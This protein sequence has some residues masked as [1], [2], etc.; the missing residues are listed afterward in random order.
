MKGSKKRSIYFDDCFA[1]STKFLR[2]QD[3]FKDGTL[4]YTDLVFQSADE[5]YEVRA[6]VSM[7]KDPILI[8]QF[9]YKG[10]LKRIKVDL[11]VRVNHFG[12]K[13]YYFVCPQSRRNCEKI[14]FVHGVVACRAFHGLM[15]SSQV[16]DNRIKKL[17]AKYGAGIRAENALRELNTPGL[18]MH[19][20]GRPTK[21]VKRLLK[22][23]KEGENCPD[24]TMADLSRL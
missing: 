3:F 2:Q 10:D 1:L 9:D 22:L 11:S 16:K 20:K 15:D 6:V 7:D 18:R 4:N 24:F 5:G 8:L 12:G 21:R 13:G 17:D 14:Y 19:H 23:I